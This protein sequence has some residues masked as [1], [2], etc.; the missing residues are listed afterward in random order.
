M[1]PSSSNGDDDG[2]PPSPS[3]YVS[4]LASMTKV[5]DGTAR[6]DLALLAEEQ[7]GGG[8]GGGGSGPLR[9]LMYGGRY[10]MKGSMR[11]KGRWQP[12]MIVEEKRKILEAYTLHS[13]RV[14]VRRVGRGGGRAVERG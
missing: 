6:G 5:G 11:R 7:R 13:L 1:S 2:P 12:L 10:T 8:G 9:M 14:I 3:M 4:V